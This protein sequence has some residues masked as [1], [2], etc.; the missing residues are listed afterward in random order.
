MTITNF[1]NGLSSFGVPL[2]GPGGEL[3]VSG[4]YYF[5]DSGSGADGNQGSY[6]SPMATLDAAIGR[7]VASQGD[8]IVLMPGHAETVSAAG[9]IACDVAGISIIGLGVGNLRPTFTF[10]ATAATIT[11]SAANIAIANI[12]TKPSVDSVVSPIVVSAAGCSIS[13]EHQDASSAI[14]AVR[15]ILTTAA[16]DNLTINLVYKGFIAGNACVNAVRLVGGDNVN[17]TVDFY[18]VASTAIVEFL[19]TAVTNATISGYFYNSGTTNLSKD[20]VDTV[21]GSTWFVSG[22]DGAAGASFS[23]GSGAAVS[24]DDISTVISNQAVPTADST[25]NVLERDVI[26]NKTDAAATGSVSATESLMAYAKQNVTNTEKI[27]TIANTAGT[28]TIGGVLGDVANVD[29]ATRTGVPTADVATDNSIATTV[30][31]KTDAAV[32]AVGTT[33]SIQAYI[34]GL[35]DLQEKVVVKSAAVMVDNDTLF[36]IA[37]GPIKIEALWSE[38]VTGND[39]TA[40]TVAYKST[41]TTGSEQTI[42]AASASIAN[43]AAG[44]SIALAGTALATAALYNANGANLIANPGTI[45]VPAGTLDIDVAVGSTTGTWRH[46]LRYK[47]LASGVTVT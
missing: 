35:T 13:I 1:P 8:V 44:A 3:P 5:V 26:G 21:T 31:R 14:E 40:S 37:G 22:Y 47:P 17:V 34:K 20:V 46:Y 33:K 36:T 43:A 18:G 25:A 15:A 16:A 28:A 19:T 24:A 32:T 41:P 27:G 2:L 29:L 6:D 4:T 11:V 42:S 7:C 39:A 10:S 30:G 38:C 45:V 23:G 9:G 12:I